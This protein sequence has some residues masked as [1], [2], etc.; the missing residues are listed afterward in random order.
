MDVRSVVLGLRPRGGGTCGRGAASG[1][2]RCFGEDR[3]AEIR[4]NWTGLQIILPTDG[5]TA[6][7]DSD[8]F[9]MV[10]GEL[11]LAVDSYRCANVL[12]DTALR[13]RFGRFR[14]QRDD[15]ATFEA[16]VLTDAMDRYEGGIDVL[17]W[18]AD[19]K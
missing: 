18:Q 8:R 9:Y 6:L 3:V 19:A 5:A 12:K 15:F 10:Y 14:C 11:H 13:P 7:I 2:A 17:P 4:G 1:R 16:F